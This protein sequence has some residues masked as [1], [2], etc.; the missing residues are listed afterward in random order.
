LFGLAVSAGSFFLILKSIT[1]YKGIFALVHFV[2]L[3]VVAS[4]SWF[5]IEKPLNNLKKYFV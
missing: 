3:V 2:V 4:I 1:G 5:L